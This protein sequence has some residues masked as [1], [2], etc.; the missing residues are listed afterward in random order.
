MD[1]RWSPSRSVIHLPVG[2]EGRCIS[3]NPCVRATATALNMQCLVLFC[4]FVY[5]RD[6][7]AS[8]AP[9]SR[10]TRTG[11]QILFCRLRERV[12]SGPPKACEKD[13]LPFYS[14]V[15]SV[16]LDQVSSSTGS[17]SCWW[18]S[19]SV[20]RSLRRWTQPDRSMLMSNTW[21][22]SGTIYLFFQMLIH[23]RPNGYKIGEP[24]TPNPCV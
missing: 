2:G 17:L 6:R 14:F 24:K 9:T 4:S 13:F 19:R 20:F 12:W 21:I 3:F 1:Q 18:R 22:I 15:A 11:L 8:Q 5:K 16:H 7:S 10:A 23:S